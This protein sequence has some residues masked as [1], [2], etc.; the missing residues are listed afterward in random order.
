LSDGQKCVSGALGLD[1]RAVGLDE[2]DRCRC[3][4]GGDGVAVRVVE[5]LRVVEADETMGIERSE[6]VNDVNGVEDRLDAKAVVGVNAGRGRGELRAVTARAVRRPMRGVLWP[7]RRRK[8]L[9]SV[10]F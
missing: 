6:R 3:E 8:R 10:D 5:R 9:A 2:V 4:G 1:F 7:M